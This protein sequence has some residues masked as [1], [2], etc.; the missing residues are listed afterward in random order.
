M[1]YALKNASEYNADYV[2][3][4]GNTVY[5]C[6]LNPSKVD[7]NSATPIE[8]QNA[9]RIEKNETI[10]LA[11]GDIEMRTTYPNGHSTDYN[12]AAASCKTYTYAY[13]V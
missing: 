4:S 11:N 2:L 10:K 1:L 13:Q 12:F 9:W 7:Y 8:Q 5:L 6:F 3:E